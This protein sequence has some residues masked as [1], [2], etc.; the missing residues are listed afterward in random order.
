MDL[1]RESNKLDRQIAELCRFGPLET[2]DAID[3]YERLNSKRIRV[4]RR[5]G[6]AW[7]SVQHGEVR[8]T[9]TTGCVPS[10]ISR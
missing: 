2:D 3:V 9:A 7:W 4:Q 6:W 8:S 10:R 5:L 1:E